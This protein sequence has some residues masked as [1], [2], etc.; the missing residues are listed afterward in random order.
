M[1]NIESV[2]KSRHSVRSYKDQKIEGEVLNELQKE[3]QKCSEESGL[4]IKLVLNEEKAFGKTHYGS[5]DN[6][7]NYIV[8]MGEKN[9][10]DLDEASGY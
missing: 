3:I 2:V 5:F 8:I 7:K 6:C 4:N 9:R 10:K 1:N